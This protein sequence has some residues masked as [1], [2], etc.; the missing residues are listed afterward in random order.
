MGTAHPFAEEH[1]VWLDQSSFFFFL[2]ICV[3]RRF[4]SS[5]ATCIFAP[6][7]LPCLNY[8]LHLVVIVW[9]LALDAS[10][11]RKTSMSFNYLVYRNAGTPFKCIYVLRETCV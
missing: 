8:F 3:S 2:S 4:T 5:F 10:L 9:H 1:N 11:R 6:W 7:Y